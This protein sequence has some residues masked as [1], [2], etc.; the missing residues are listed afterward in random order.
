MPVVIAACS[1]RKM[2][3]P[4]RMLRGSSVPK[5]S[6]K[7]VA[8]SWI[9]RVRAA[10]DRTPADTLYC[11]RSF[12]E[13]KAAA[14]K[15]SADFYI[16]SAGLGLVRQDTQ[17]PAYNITVAGP[18]RDNVLHRVTQNS[19]RDG[20][21]AWWRTL[22]RLSP[23]GND[24]HDVVRNSHGLVLIALPSGY[25]DMLADD[26]GKVHAR[27]FARARIFTRAIPKSFP[28]KLLSVVMPYD[29]RLDG[30]DS[31]MPGT[32][33]DFAARALRHFVDHVVSAMPN[34]DLEAHRQAV[35]S[36][37]EKLRSRKNVT[38]VRESD[39]EL[40]RL[41]RRS[42]KAADGKSSR[43]LRVLRDDLG[44]AC[45][46]SRFVRL[47]AEAKRQRARVRL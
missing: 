24:L 23:V 30:P 32:R 7:E 3:K 17:I 10:N 18:T 41:I 20:T 33:S 16:A 1:N 5:G 6:L 9:S 38:R 12:L 27:S 25:L 21:R 19:A 39:D 2:I 31:S 42:W 37:M 28:K 47:F 8:A 13:A 34:G 45:E 40:I 26:L 46:Q 4:T 29:E 15:L 43:M 36:A 35:A 11:G 44:V 14:A 22:S